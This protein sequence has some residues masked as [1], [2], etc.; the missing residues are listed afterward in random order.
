MST[1]EQIEDPPHKWRLVDANE[2]L[3]S[4]ILKLIEV[5]NLE[6]KPFVAISYRWTKAVTDWRARIIEYSNLHQGD[7]T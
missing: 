5:S 6:E 4:G 1:G 7:L 3:Y 2:Y